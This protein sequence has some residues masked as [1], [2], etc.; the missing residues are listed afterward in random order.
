MS[1]KDFHETPDYEKAPVTPILNIIQTFLNEVKLYDAII[2]LP[3]DKNFLKT[4][5]TII[6]HPEFNYIRENADKLGTLLPEIERIVG[7]KFE[8]TNLFADNRAFSNFGRIICAEPF[9]RSDG[10]LNIV[11][12]VLNSEDFNGPDGREIRSLSSKLISY[13]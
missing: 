6:G 13:I 8:P 9:P 3:I 4:V 11:D 5:I 2:Q 10:N 12:N 7:D 1:P